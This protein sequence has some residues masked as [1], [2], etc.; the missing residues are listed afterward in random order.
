ML[1]IKNVLKTKYI[2]SKIIYL[3][4]YL[5]IYLENNSFK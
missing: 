3:S 4:I 1:Y 5:S 2:Y